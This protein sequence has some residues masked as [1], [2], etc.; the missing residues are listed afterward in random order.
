MPRWASSRCCVACA[1][2]LALCRQRAISLRQPFCKALGNDWLAGNAGFDPIRRPAAVA[3]PADGVMER[4]AQV[5]LWRNALL[6]QFDQITRQEGVAGIRQ[7]ASI[8]GLGLECEFVVQARS[9]S[10]QPSSSATTASIT[11]PMSAMWGHVSGSGLPVMVMYRSA[12]R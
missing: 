7:S 6:D 1:L 4:G 8:P 11:S 5:V 9:P 3:K 10:L 2:V 12:P